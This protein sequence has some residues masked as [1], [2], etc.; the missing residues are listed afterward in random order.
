MER[1]YVGLPNEMNTFS[2]NFYSD[3][4]QFEMVHV[5]GSNAWAGKL[6]V[7]DP[8]MYHGPSLYRVHERVH[9]EEAVSIRLF[10]F[11]TT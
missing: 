11:E 8:V 2:C 3:I 10:V 4:A 5:L 1:R 6:R 7:P 9:T